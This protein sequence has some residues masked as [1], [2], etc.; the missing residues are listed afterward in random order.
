MDKPLTASQ[1]RIGAASSRPEVPAPPNDVAV[2]S[3]ALRPPAVGRSHG[4]PSAPGAAPVDV[5]A[6]LPRL[7]AG[8]DGGANCVQLSPL[9][10]LAHAMTAFP[11]EDH[12]RHRLR[13]LPRPPGDAGWN[14]ELV[15]AQAPLG[16]AE[17]ADTE[18]AIVA[19]IAQDLESHAKRC[20]LSEDER[21]ALVQQVLATFVDAHS[22]ELRATLDR[23]QAAALVVAGMARPKMRP[24][25]PVAQAPVPRADDQAPPGPRTEQQGQRLRCG[26]L[27]LAIASH[28][29]VELEESQDCVKAM[30]ADQRTA[31]DAVAVAQQRLDI[32][33]AFRAGS[34]ACPLDDGELE[35]HWQDVAI[36]LAAIPPNALTPKALRLTPESSSRIAKYLTELWKVEPLPAEAPRAGRGPS[37]ARRQ[38]DARLATKEWLIALGVKDIQKTIKALKACEHAP[39]DAKQVPQ[40]CEDLLFRFRATRAIGYHLL[41]LEVDDRVRG[42]QQR[43]VDWVHGH[44]DRRAVTEL[45][46]PLIDARIERLDA[47]ATQN[48][49]GRASIAPEGY[50]R[51]AALIACLD[52]RASAWDDLVLREAHVKGLRKAKV[53]GL[54]ASDRA[55]LDRIFDR[56]EATALAAE[57][58][59]QAANHAAQVS[60]A[61]I[62]AR[63]DKAPPARPGSVAGG[64]LPGGAGG[65]PVTPQ[66]LFG[67]NL[68]RGSQ[69]PGKPRREGEVHHDKLKDKSASGKERQ[70]IEQER[71]A[72]AQGQALHLWRKV[73]HETR[74]WKHALAQERRARDAK[75]A[76]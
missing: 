18:A 11:A 68:N 24:Q 4:L 60:Q 51:A 67:P 50:R 1:D 48:A 32:L 42:A 22:G 46:I 23:L 16:P 37:A 43:E 54:T 29:A 75:S 9:A 56:L 58:R 3:E 64:N 25:L 59:L 2:D 13:V 28:M 15:D 17:Q 76:R 70:R 62:P 69:G 39:I 36:L 57:G 20:K 6:G 63:E 26:A 35:Q 5:A 8:A 30:R 14:V 19:W 49:P 66:E 7:Q 40:A 73:K 44:E 53:P 55:R 31:V 38:H 27:A 41:S 12:D 21:R 33:E 47:A 65:P 72:Q 52:E 45:A 61:P 74:A 34:R 10:G 71:Q